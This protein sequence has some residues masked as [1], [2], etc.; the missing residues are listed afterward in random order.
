[1]KL[2]KVNRLLVTILFVTQSVV[3]FGQTTDD[4]T[5][6]DG[7]IG[8]KTSVVQSEEILVDTAERVYNQ[9]SSQF[10]TQTS[11][12]S[13]VQYNLLY[14]PEIT[15]QPMTSVAAIYRLKINNT[16]ESQR[17]LFRLGLG[18][19]GT[20]MLDA[21]FGSKRNTKY[22]YGLKF[23]HLGSLNGSVN[24]R[25]SGFSYNQISAHGK[26]FIKKHI[27]EIN[28]GYRRQVAK[29][30]GYINAIEQYNS[31]SLVESDS[32]LTY[33]ESIKTPSNF[34]FGRINFRNTGNSN[35][36][37]NA[38]FSPNL[39]Q[40]NPILKESG[41]ITGINTKQSTSIGEF[42]LPIQFTY[43]SFTNIDTER[44][45]RSLLTVAPSYNKHSDDHRLHLRLGANIN[46]SSDPSLKRKL[47]I[48][49][50][51]MGSYILS[52]D[53]NL[54][55]STRIYGGINQHQLGD[56]YELNPW[57]SEK[58][59]TASTLDKLALSC[60]LYTSDAADD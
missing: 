36:K 1:M 35:F 59:Q 4:E 25:E 11:S 15:L 39:S 50:E 28:G 57:L 6:G 58:S 20:S 51:L 12:P 56:L 60:L 3:F 40:I 49:P 9:A 29:N 17:G 27:V 13:E 2:E 24:K 32:N 19:L 37:Y 41:I 22:S 8:K 5:S 18:N 47:F 46:Y 55:F 33:S 38:F 7:L 43:N 34:V 48:F 14:S 23:N 10:N 45:N 44:L 16:D 26:Y 52:Q 31:L 30:Y 21:Y 54:V 53:Y 42:S